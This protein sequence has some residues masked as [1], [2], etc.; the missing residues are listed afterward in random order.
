MRIL[1]KKIGI[2]LVG[3]LMILL[4]F[5]NVYGQQYDAFTQVE[6]SNGLSENKVRNISQLNDGRMLISTKGILNLYNGAS[7]QYIHLNEGKTYSLPGYTGHLHTYIG[8]NGRFWLKNNGILML[9]NIATEHYEDNAGQIISS[10]GIHEQLADFFMDTEKNMWMLGTTGKLFFKAK[11]QSKASVFLPN[12]NQTPDPDPLFDI[13]LFNKNLYLFYRSGLIVCYSLS[14]HKE[15]FR[16]YSL[17]KQS[18]IVYNKTL[19]IVPGNNTLYMLRNSEKDGIMLAYNEKDNTWNTVIKTGYRLNTLSVGP[20]GDIILSCKKGLWKITRNLNS[21]IFIPTIHLSDGTSINTEVSSVFYDNQGGLWLGTFN[22]GL[23]YYHPDRFRFKNISK[24]LFPNTNKETLTVTGFSEISTGIMLVSTNQGVYNLNTTNN[25]LTPYPNLEHIACNAILK[26]S[27]NRIWISSTSGLYCISG[28]SLQH[29]NSENINNTL[30]VSDSTL[31][32]STQ[33]QGLLKFNIK[34]GAIEK[35]TDNKT[36]G[37]IKSVSQV[38]Q[39]RGTLTG[40]SNS[41][42]FQYNIKNKKLKLLSKGSQKNKYIFSQNNHQYNCLFKDTR[43]L[44]WIGTEDGLNVW[45]G[46]NNFKSFHTEDGLINNTIQSIT[47]DNKGV[48]WISTSN[49]VSCL[50]Y[51]ADGGIDFRVTN[52]TQHDGLINN[53]FVECSSYVTKQGSVFF[54]GIDGF[55]YLQTKRTANSSED[56]MPIFISLQVSG[57][58]I[59]RDKIYEGNK[60][61]TSPIVN[62]RGITLKHDQNFLKIGFSALNFINPTQTKYQYYLEGVDNNWHEEQANGGLGYA[63]YTDLFPGTYT[64]KVRATNNDL[65]WGGKINTLKIKI[66]APWWQTKIAIIIYLTVLSIIIY[67]S[68]SWYIKKNKI[69]R[70]KLQQEYLDQMKYNFFTNLSHE[71]RTPLTLIINPIDAIFKTTRDANIKHQLGGIR[72]NANVLLNLV[73]QL[74]N[75]RRLEMNG[76]NLHLSYCEINSLAA[77]FANPFDELAKNKGITFI[78]HI[79]NIDFWLYVDKDKL[80][81][82]INNLLSNAFKFTPKYGK[83]T[84]TI[85][86]AV[87]PNQSRES[88]LISVEDTGCGILE[89]DQKEIFN[90]FYQANNQTETNTGSG[91]GLYLTNEYV[92][93]HKGLVTLTSTFGN[94]SNFNIYIPH[95]LKPNIHEETY[96]TPDGVSE[97]KNAKIMI[98]E[99]NDEFREFLINQLNNEYDTIDAAN[100]NDGLKII[101]EQLP[102]LIISDLMMPGITGLDLCKTL[103]KDLRTSHIPFILLTA[104]AS[105]EAEIETYQAGADTYITKPF[106]ADIL[107]IKIHNLID[108]AAQRKALFK[109]AIV[110]QPS[111]VTTS[112]VDEKFI[113]RALK[114][115]EDNIAN[116]HYSVEDF[117]SDMNMERT[118]LY[119]KIVAV[120]GQTPTVFMRSVRLK[121]AALLIKQNEFSIAEISDMVGFNNVAYFSKCFHEEFHIQPSRY[122]DYENTNTLQENN[123]IK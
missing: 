110:I 82:I 54:G 120:V 70:G 42:L 27:K 117:S 49:G 86:K 21:K 33:T 107:L 60:I 23:L 3:V 4:L 74:L 106:N 51:K 52:F 104:R 98:I 95:D 56:R 78:K 116:V 113:K 62:S 73:N 32:L 50:N 9:V 115:I 57:Q 65:R 14:S 25:L 34:N 94:G 79:D 35:V 87:M 89:K 12:I 31:Y 41:G 59:I 48:I 19:Y 55:N 101:F 2:K 58:D 105:Y 53:E 93:L 13:A 80:G 123:L 5:N 76:E 68:A 36:E 69:K 88:V 66:N 112:D 119:R 22:K 40:I 29:Y 8:N 30:Q 121:K 100:G 63:T 96:L 17:P 45:D 15:I 91:I 97:K 16:E 71:L 77:A 90:R 75:F 37:Q 118:G 72:H 114:C 99:D 102:D 11:N 38:I 10:F 7:F 108:Q 24:S 47:E 83:I 61:L 111:H 28:R 67:I 26:D 39:W 46:K 43:N 84:F 122:L 1:T 18:S 6:S 103:K 44:L 109:K 64:L 85:K 20:N 92:K 81:I